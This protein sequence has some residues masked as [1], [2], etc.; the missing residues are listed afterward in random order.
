MIVVDTV[1]R[2]TTMI[3]DYKER[4]VLLAIL[5][6]IPDEHAMKSIAEKMAQQIKDTKADD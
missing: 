1:E 3:L 5:E 6:S 4:G 2:K